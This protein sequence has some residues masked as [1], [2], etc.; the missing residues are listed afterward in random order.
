MQ[1]LCKLDTYKVPEV[2]MVAEKWRAM[3]GCG[4]TRGGLTLA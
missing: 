2:A 3:E 4:E 1:E